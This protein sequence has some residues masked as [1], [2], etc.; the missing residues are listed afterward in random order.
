MSM[1]EPFTERARRSIVLAQEEAQ[2]LGNNYIGTE[3]IL[4][5]IISEGESLAAKVLESLGVNLAKVR[6]EVEAIVGR[7]GQT[8]QQEMV[9]TP[10]AKRVIELAFEEARQLNHNYIGT[11]HLL[12]GLI[13]EGEGVAARVL[14]N[15]GVDPAKVRTQTTS[16]LGAEGQ[17]APPK[18]KSKTPTLDSYGRDLTQL[19]RDNKLDPVIGRNTEIER[20]I[21]ILARRTKNNPALIGEPGVGKTA[22]AEGLAQRVIKG[23]IPEP[24]RDKRVITLDLA[25]LVAGTKYRG[26]FEERMKRVMDEIRGAAG[27]I[28]L[29][30]DELHTLVGAGAAEG[31]IDASNIIKPALARGEL[32][33]IGATTLNEFR[34]HIEKDS[35]LE[36]RFQPVMVGEPSVEETIEILRG[37]RDR[38]EAHHKVQ[39]TDEALAAAAKLSDRYITDR[40]LP[41]KAV[42]LIDEA[43][44]RVRLQA[45]LPPQELRDLENQ[46]RKVISDKE[47]VVK[48]Q[49]FDKAASIRDREEKLRLEKARL[50]SEWRE[51]KGTER[52]LRVTEESIAEI[53]SAWTKIPVSKLAQAETEKLLKMKD[54]LH[55]RVIG[56]DEAI[57]V[58]TRAI[59]RSRAGLKSPSR[60]IGSFIFLGPTG[61][62]KTEVA[63]SVAGFLFDDEE[64]MIRID[65]SEYMEKYSVSRLVGAPP[66]YVGYE[67]GGQLTEAVRRRPYSVVLLDEIEKAHPDVFNLLLQVLD[68]GRLT[69][70]QGRQVDFKNTVIVMTSNVGAIGIQTTTDIGFRMQKTGEDDEARAYERMKNKVMEEVK[71]T[72]RPEFLNRVDEVV[73]FHQLTRPEIEAIVTLELEKV[74]REVRAQEME[75][76][77]TDAAKAVLAKKGWD[78]QFGARPLR[79]AIQRMVEDE[80][81]EEMLKGTLGSGDHILGDID[82]N[83]PEK[84]KYTK[85]PSIEPPAAPTTEAAVS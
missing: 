38:Y 9:F 51:R 43:S 35:A 30:I 40:F 79:R 14:T 19:A 31:A 73:V 68:D 49:E 7:G 15:L 22:I 85:I 57:E 4:L 1:W 64:S 63:R 50:E 71:Q 32:Q 55:E 75:L 27:E 60:P 33:C 66:G 12:L 6:Q 28:I 80:L 10:R 34:K 67:E 29:F 47:L 56:Q 62:G 59:R 3:H 74:A 72:F 42:D 46:L 24:L 18:G 23:D 54:L 41:D 70:S 13:R 36:R 53:V 81:A 25:G 84:L 78:P 77:V 69:D 44:S 2:R 21:Q 65:M 11:E 52:I 76:K 83:D 26:E 5:G 61:V 48:T 82:P 45:T 16:L 37:L 58:I 20:V 17:P 8:V 39:I